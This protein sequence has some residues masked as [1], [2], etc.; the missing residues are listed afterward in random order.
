MGRSRSCGWSC[1]SDS[2]T[3]ND[4]SQPDSDVELMR[5]ENHL[6]AR[7]GAEDEQSNEEGVEEST[8]LESLNV[9]ENGE[10]WRKS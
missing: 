8:I 1:G 4:N 7:G 6:E 9:E 2:E 10:E 3:G 5:T